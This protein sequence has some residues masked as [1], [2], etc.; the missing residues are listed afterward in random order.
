MGLAA[1]IAPGIR[2]PFFS[3]SPSP[4]LKGYCTFNVTVA[5]SVTEPL[6]AVTVRV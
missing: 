5:D 3:Y 2:A 1:V 6:V 4:R